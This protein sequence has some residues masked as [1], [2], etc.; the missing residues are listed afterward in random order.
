M[1][2]KYIKKKEKII[3]PMDVGNKKTEY[4]KRKKKKIEYT[5]EEKPKVTNQEIKDLGKKAK[6]AFKLIKKHFPKIGTDY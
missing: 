3:P 1:S 2:T 5:K 6:D 4:I